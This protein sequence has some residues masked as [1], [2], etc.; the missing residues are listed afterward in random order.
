MGFVERTLV[1]TWTFAQG[2][3]PVNNLI[4]VKQH[5]HCIN[6]QNINLFIR[7]EAH[8]GNFHKCDV[9]GGNGDQR[10]IERKEQKSDLSLE[11]QKG[12]QSLINRN[13]FKRCVGKREEQSITVKG[14]DRAISNAHNLQFW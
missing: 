5:H 7:Q 9:A 4:S 6:K 14:K 13:V 10:E 11:K 12:R 1:Q 8:G 2:L 3:D